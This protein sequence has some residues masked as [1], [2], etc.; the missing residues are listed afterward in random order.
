MTTTAT[1][2]AATASASP[3]A[4]RRRRWYVE[5]LP[6][7]VALALGAVLRVVTGLAFTPGLMISDS[8]T[9]L[10]FLEHPSPHPDRP[11]GYGLLLLEPL[12]PF[13]NT[14]TA[15]AVAQHLLGLGTAVVLYVLMRRWRVRR[16]PATLATL[17]VLLDAMQVFF[18]STPLSDVFFGTLVTAGLAVLAWRRRPGPMLALAAGLL[19]GASATVRQVGMPLVVAGGA[20]CLLVGR[21]GWARLV[22]ALALALGFTLPVTAY[23]AW[24]ESE[25]GVF[26]LS[27]IGGKSAYMRTTTFVDCSQLSLPDYQRVLCPPEP[28]GERLDPTDY[29][30]YSWGTVVRLQPP[31]GT[32]QDE[33][34]RGFARA[35]VRAQPLDYVT[36]VLRD[37][38]L[39]FDVSRGDR[40]EFNT[41]SK[42]LFRTVVDSPPTD[43]AAGAYSR[44]GGEQLTVHQPY[45]GALVAY[46]RVGYLPGPAVLA[47]LLL[48]LAGGLGLGRARGSGMR[49]VCLLITVSGM[50]LALAP[51]VTTE[52]IWR[53]QLPSVVLVP[54]GAALAW[55][56]LRGG[57][58]DVRD[59]RSPKHRTPRRRG[60]SADV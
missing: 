29:G 4:P 12:A 22:P 2:D 48:G 47:C 49:S 46:Q 39:S 53:Y 32:T 33:A 8:V 51:A 56:A 5:H 45:A 43:W 36:T 25:H 21:G 1:A 57:R 17:P 55:T 35:A 59:D 23:A 52:F 18:E 41:A 14:V 11:M 3:A 38:A 13:G 28:R 60:V 19:L 50:G 10:G 30:W 40:Y 16:W 9:Y 42:W 58:P 34:L 15:V 6:F 54:V 27:Q 20:Y 24:Y 7:L 44:H 26:A 37:M 31:P